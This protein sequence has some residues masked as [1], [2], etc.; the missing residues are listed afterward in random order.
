[1]IWTTGHRSEAGGLAVIA[2]G[3]GP[4]VLLIHG[5]GLRA[6]AWGAQID[7]LARTCSVLAVDMPG[8]G[9]SLRLP[10][11]ATLADYT[12]AIA[13]TLDAPAVVIGHSFGAMIALDLAIRHP[14]RVA[15]IAALN[16]IYRRSAEAKAA[17]RA[18]AESL[19]G[20][21][22]ADP[23]ATLE[24]WFG[25]ATSPERDACRDWLCSNDPLG[26]RTAYGVFAS[27][28]GPTD[29]GLRELH[30]PALFLTGGQERNSTPE[31]SHAMA[32]L[33]P[34]GHTEV[35]H[36]AAHMLP[37]TNAPQVNAILERFVREVFP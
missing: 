16:A 5:V 34:Q 4:V 27:E 6:E 31:M 20:L 23:S 14:G 28:D 25:T 7:V 1:M 9:D 15:G 10:A 24:R 2:A 18:R 26:Y 17:V 22:M 35:L 32:T 21:S 29:Q 37:M 36:D 19:D 33:A 12:D 13:A 30:C 3:E 11:T 8:H